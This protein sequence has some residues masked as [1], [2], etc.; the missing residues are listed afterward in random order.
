MKWKASE[1]GVREERRWG[2][3]AIEMEEDDEEASEE[4]EEIGQEEEE[5]LDK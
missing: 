5:G 3:A 2:D 1:I 4:E